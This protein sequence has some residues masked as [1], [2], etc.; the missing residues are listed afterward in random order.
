MIREILSPDD[1]VWPEL[2]A[3]Y[4]ASF[5]LAEREPVSTLEEEL[6]SEGPVRYW[7]AETD[8]G[9]AG[10]VRA[11][12][13]P[14]ARAAITIH[15][16]VRLDRREGGWGGRLLD[17]AHEG[18]GVERPMLFEVERRREAATDAERA[19]CEARLAWFKARGCW[20]VSGD[21]TQ[22]ALRAETGPVR[23]HLL[24]R[25]PR[26]DRGELIRGLYADVWKLSADHEFVRRAESDLDGEAF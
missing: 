1:A 6:R 21:Y 7:V 17:V 11:A 5:P 10:F 8:Q 4:E 18:F 25:G 3:L 15:I 20:A 24:A 19:K 12:D 23:M 9:F 2:V 14:S 16:A 13:L 26:A 22:P